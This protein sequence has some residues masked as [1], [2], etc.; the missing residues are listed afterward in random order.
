MRG[1]VQK[2]TG[3]WYV[4]LELERGEDGKRRQ[5]WI[6]VREE[7]GLA[8]PATKKQAEALLTEKLKQLQDGTYFEPAEITVREYLE[9]WLE[10][11]KT[12]VRQKTY[13]LTEM[14]IRN[15]II[16]E[17]GHL[18]LT[19]LKPAHLQAL[20]MKKLEDGRCD[21]KEGGLSTRS[22]RYVHQV[23]N[24]ALKQAVK[25]ELVTR[26]VAEA[27][28][29]PKEKQ[30]ERPTWT[31]EQV[32]IFLDSCKTH[33]LYPLYL[34]A[35]STGM[36]RGE[37][38]GLRWKDIDWANS[39]LYVQQTLV[40][41][42]DGLKLEPPKTE[43]SRRRVALS[44]GVLEVLKAHRKKQM[45]DFFVLG[46]PEA[47]KE[48]VFTSEAGTLINPRNLNRNFKYLIKK[49]NEDYKKQHQDQKEDVLPTIPFHGLRHTHAT[50]MLKAGAHTKVVSERLGHAR[51]SITMDIYSHVLPDMQ[52]EAAEQFD[53]ILQLSK[54]E[55]KERTQG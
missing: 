40:S 53:A 42:K 3:N 47:I 15:H 49:A 10:F 55:K 6:S 14:T 18:K 43:K 7:L 54:G 35:L 36:R 21:G 52:A 44:K 30:K 45:E 19:Q 5:K 37:I 48:M 33:R 31:A 9:R 41:T 4:V 28:D 17:I 8:K 12:T 34:L 38:L 24:R 29:P 16:P 39:A 32:A 23:L 13:D 1:H 2:K 27:V 11:A 46:G 51:T 50:L 22:V 25:W 20:Y 26:N